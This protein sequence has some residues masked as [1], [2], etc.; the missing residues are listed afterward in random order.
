MSDLIRT[1][2]TA[3]LALPGSSRDTTAAAIK[4]FYAQVRRVSEREQ[5][6]EERNVRQMIRASRSASIPTTYMPPRPEL[7]S[8]ITQVFGTVNVMG[9]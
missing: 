2:R 4:D 5:R 3:M 8:G 6:A 9:R 1:A 7:R